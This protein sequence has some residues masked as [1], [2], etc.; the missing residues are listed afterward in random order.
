MWKQSE[1][2]RQA[3]ASWCAT[4]HLPGPPRNLEQ[5]FHAMW[6]QHAQTLASRYQNRIVDTVKSKTAGAIWHCEDHQP[7][8]AVCYCP[9]LCHNMLDGTFCN[10]AVF[11]EVTQDFDGELRKVQQ[12]AKRALQCRYPWAFRCTPKVPAACALPKRTKDF[13]AGRPIISFV[14]AFMRPLLEAT[15]RLRSTAF[16]QAFAK[17]DVY[18]LRYGPFLS[19]ALPNHCRRSQDLAGFFSSIAK[20]QFLHAWRITLEFYRQRHGIQPDAIAGRNLYD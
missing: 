6:A 10:K 15:S 2:F 14:D 13:Q 7:R 12:A 8:A 16:P 18:E 5:V 17:G 9:V 3:W 20:P 19:K 1:Q 4:N 11:Q